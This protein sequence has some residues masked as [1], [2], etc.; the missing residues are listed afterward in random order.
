VVFAATLD[1]AELVEYEQP[2]IAGAAEI[3][4]VGAAFLLTLGA[5]RH[6]AE[7]GRRR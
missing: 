5:E 4:I 7:R 2:V 3:A 6:L 1:I